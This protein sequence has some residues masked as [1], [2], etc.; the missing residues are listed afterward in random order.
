M[1]YKHP[2]CKVVP[3]APQTALLDTSNGG[4]SGARFNDQGEYDDG[5]GWV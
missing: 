3:I 1:E 5:E 4:K 2:L